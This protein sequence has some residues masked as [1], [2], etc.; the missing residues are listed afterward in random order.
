MRAVCTPFTRQL[1]VRMELRDPRTNQLPPFHHLPPHSPRAHGAESRG[2]RY[3]WSRWHVASS[4]LSAE[5]SRAERGEEASHCATR[6]CAAPLTEADQS[7]RKEPGQKAIRSHSPGGGG[8]RPR[9]RPRGASITA[10]RRGQGRLRSRCPDT[11]ALRCPIIAPYEDAFRATCRSFLLRNSR[12]SMSGS[13]AV[14][15]SCHSVRP[16]NNKELNHTHHSLAYTHGHVIMK[17]LIANTN[18]LKK[19]RKKHLTAFTINVD[20]VNIRKRFFFCFNV[21]CCSYIA[22]LSR[23]NYSRS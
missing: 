21:F 18:R 2:Q 12:M 14:G 13:L 6:Y 10:A 16:R 4:A 20:H 9:C 8:G 19:K 5:P 17:N 23:V 7:D 15:C 3:G 1:T 11:R 22:L